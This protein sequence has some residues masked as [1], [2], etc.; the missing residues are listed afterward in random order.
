MRSPGFARRVGGDL[1]LEIDGRRVRLTPIEQKVTEAEGAGGLDTLRFDAVF[2]AEATGS[3]LVLRDRT[4]R[5]SVGGVVVRARYGARIVSS[6]RRR[7]SIDGLR[8]YPSD[9]LSSPLGVAR[10]GRIEPGNAGGR[11]ASLG[12]DR[13]LR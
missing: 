2:A 10:L 9:L 4:R 13:S 3:S 8:A 6:R 5:G 11:G 12:T 7:E 1:V